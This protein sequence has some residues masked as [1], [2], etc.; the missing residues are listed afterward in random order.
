M[1]LGGLANAALRV[2]WRWPITCNG[3]FVQKGDLGRSPLEVVAVASHV[4]GR[5]SGGSGFDVNPVTW[6]VL[7]ESGIV[8]R[9]VDRA[10]LGVLRDDA[11]LRSWTLGNLE[12]YWRPW[13]AGVRGFGLVAAKALAMRYVAWGVLGTARMHFTVA[14]GGIASKAA[15]ADYALQTFG[16]RWRDLLEETRAYWVGGPRVSR[17]KSALVRRRDTAEFVTEVIDSARAI[18][19]PLQ[20]G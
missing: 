8:V 4:A 18:A 6:R 3:V 11:E 20:S 10:H 1:F 17:Y 5:F 7:S 16:S 12:S 13:A 2:P 19:G 15:A 9:G 14:T